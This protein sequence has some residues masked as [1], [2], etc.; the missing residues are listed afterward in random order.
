MNWLMRGLVLGVCRVGI[1]GFVAADPFPSNRIGDA[2]GLFFCEINT[3]VCLTHFEFP[4][5]P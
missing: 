3:V 4:S 2:D 5:Q 1:P